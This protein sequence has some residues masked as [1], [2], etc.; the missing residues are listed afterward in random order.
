VSA[1]KD[2]A[3]V[4]HSPLAP[5]MSTEIGRIVNAILILV[6]VYAES[7]SSA[8]VPRTGGTVTNALANATSYVKKAPA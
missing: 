1:T 2:V 6:K 4:K 5:K 3:L 7:L 8:T